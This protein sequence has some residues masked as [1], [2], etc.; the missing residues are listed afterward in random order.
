MFAI[1]GLRSLFTVLSKAASD[2]KYLEPAVAIVLGFIGLKMIFE[3]FGMHVPTE[4]SLGVVITLLSGGI[5]LSVWEK[6][7]NG[8]T[9]TTD[10]KIGYQEMNNDHSI[11][12][13][14][15]SSNEDRVLEVVNQ[16]VDERT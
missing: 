10:M 1:M 6:G 9:A 4:L 5:S 13:L 11:R 3:F 2:L 16:D 12:E 7:K 14:E 15:M 8:T